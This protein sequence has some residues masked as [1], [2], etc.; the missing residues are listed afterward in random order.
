[1]NGAVPDLRYAPPQVHRLWNAYVLQGVDWNNGMPGF[2][3]P[4]KFAFPHARMTSDD[5]AAIH[6]YVIDQAWKAYN[7]EHEQTGSKREHY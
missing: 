7:G 6:A 5:A 4:P 3:D 1:M 2:A